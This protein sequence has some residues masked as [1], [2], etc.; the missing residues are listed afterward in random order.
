MQDELFNNKTS[1]GIVTPVNSEPSV[2]QFES[3]IEF[4]TDANLYISQRV[5]ELEKFYQESITLEN[6]NN[7]KYRIL[8]LLVDSIQVQQNPEILKP[9]FSAK[10]FVYKNLVEAYNFL[11]FNVSLEARQ[12]AHEGI[13][14]EEWQD[15][16]DRQN[17][18]RSKTK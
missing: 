7:L 12:Q 11:L 15:W 10:R 14:K 13:A 1:D 18:I 8:R 5:E 17:L 6:E 4:T 16:W 9:G 3:K 2:P